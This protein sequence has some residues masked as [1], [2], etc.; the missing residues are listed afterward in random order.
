MDQLTMYDKV[1]EIL[2]Q[3]ERDRVHPFN[4]VINAQYTH[5]SNYGDY[6]VV[7]MMAEGFLYLAR[8]FS[9]IQLQS[10]ALGMKE[11]LFLELDQMA[12]EIEKEM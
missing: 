5:G 10:T 11:F 2:A 6:V 3:Y 12:D 8:S 4:L 7:N 9:A 1:L